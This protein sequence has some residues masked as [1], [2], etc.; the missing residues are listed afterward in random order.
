MSTMAFDNAQKPR[1]VPT[2]LSSAKLKLSAA[3]PA[4]KNAWAKLGWEIFRNNPRIVVD[5]GDPNL[6]N[7]DT[8][9]GKIT[10]ALDPLLFSCVTQMILDAAN[11]QGETKTKAEC[12]GHSYKSGSKSE[13]VVP[14][15]D[16]WV[17]KDK[18][19]CVFISVVNKDKEGFP[20]IKF[21][22]GPSD[23]RFMKWQHGDGTPY[24]KAEVSVLAAK[25]YVAIL[26]PLISQLLIDNYEPPEPP[27]GGFGGNRGGG[28]GGGYGGGQ[29]QGGGGGGAP[30]A[31]HD[32]DGGSDI[33][34]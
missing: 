31:V 7:R 19:G 34:F 15:A 32:D 20:V 2:I 24:T 14:L 8:D 21:I 23:Q 6:R 16:I 27:G 13:A 10:A 18:E 28:G 22:F 11:S 30:K 33:P 9:F 25:A 17:G 3:N 12:L 29:R 1:K 26:E 4:A 5:T